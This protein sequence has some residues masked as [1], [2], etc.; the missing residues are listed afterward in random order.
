MPPKKR[1]CLPPAIATESTRYFMHCEILLPHVR[2]NIIVISSLFVQTEL[3]FLEKN[4]PRKEGHPPSQ[5]NFTSVYM[6][7]K[8]CPIC[9]S[10][11]LTTG[12]AHALS[13]VDLVNPAG[14]AKVFMWRIVALGRRLTLSSKGGVPARPVSLRAEPTHCFSCKRFAKFCKEMQEKLDPPG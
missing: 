9:P 8:N 13:R 7:N 12:L 4:S 14:Q 6:R 10:Q 2:S 5:F 1:K 11:E 3:K